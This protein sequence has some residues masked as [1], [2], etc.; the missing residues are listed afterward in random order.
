MRF[1]Y[2][3]NKIV[4]VFFMILQLTVTNFVRYLRLFDVKSDDLKIK[5]I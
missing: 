5:L 3:E 1:W 2:L 4:F